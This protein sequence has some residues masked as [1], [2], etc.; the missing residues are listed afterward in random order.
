MSKETDGGLTPLRGET[1]AFRLAAGALPRRKESQLAAHHEGVAALLRRCTH[2]LGQ[3]K[4]SGS[5]FSMKEVRGVDNASCATAHHGQDGA[6]AA[7][8]SFVSSYTPYEKRGPRTSREKSSCFGKKIPSKPYTVHFVNLRGPSR[9]FNGDALKS[10]RTSAAPIGWIGAHSLGKQ[11]SQN[12]RDRRI[13]R[14]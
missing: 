4:K 13:R 7:A 5:Q 12:S 11:K 1:A 6:A 2:P 9:F 3:K 8:T 14:I 10:T